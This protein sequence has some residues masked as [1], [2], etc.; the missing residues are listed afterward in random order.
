MNIPLFPTARRSLFIGVPTL[1]TAVVA[2]ALT[3]SPA[4]A[5]DRPDLSIR[6]FTATPYFPMVGDTVETSITVRN[7]GTAATFDPVTIRVIL[8][9][10]MEPSTSIPNSECGFVAPDWVC[11]LPPLPPGESAQVTVHSVVAITAI[12]DESLPIIGTVVPD[13]KETAVD[14]NSGTVNLT[15]GGWA[16]VHGV[17][18]VDLDKDGQR[19]AGEP[20]LPVSP[21]G[22]QRVSLRGPSNQSYYQSTVTL[23]PDG[24]YTAVVPSG[25]YFVQFE[26]GDSDRYDWTLLNVGDDATDSDVVYGQGPGTRV[27]DGPQFT[28]G[29]G[30]D[31]AF[32]AGVIDRSLG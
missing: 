13:R 8:P 12:P 17:V 3:G 1:I 23:N 27:G 4:V 9:V 29:D 20:G 32:D 22:V 6:W 5:A 18:W 14:N 19:E 25:T 28:I 10:S 16:A 26:V 21:E 24:T 31:L 2:S 30:D 11:T 15:V 7:Y